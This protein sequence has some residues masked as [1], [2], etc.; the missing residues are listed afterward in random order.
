MN[1]SIDFDVRAASASTLLKT[2]RSVLG[3]L[4]RRGIVR[5]ANAP[6]GD[7]AELL[8]AKAF[9]GSLAPNSER[10]YDVAVPDGRLIQVKSRMLAGGLRRERQ[11]S[12]IR[13]WGFTHLAVVFF[14]VDYSVQRASL[15]PVDLARDASVEDRHVRGNRIM[16]F[17]VFLDQDGTEDITSLVRSAFDQLDAEYV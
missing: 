14:D 15:I 1:A 2:Y 9:G 5:T 7:L 10:S 12:T 6:T 11:L 3:E 4:R 17:D 13:T 16:A 8:V